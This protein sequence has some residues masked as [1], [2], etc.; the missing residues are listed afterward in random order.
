MVGRE[1]ELEQLRAAFDQVVADRSC[2][3]FTV[4][5]E[6]GVGKSRLV[7]EFHSGLKTTVAVGRCLP[8]GEGITYSPVVEVVKQL[9][10]RPTDGR[11][12]AAIGSLLGEAAEGSSAEEIAWAFRKTLE[13]A[14]AERP[15]VVVFDDIQWGEQTF[16]DLVEHVA[17]LSSGAP[18][19]LLCMARP[20]LIEHR[21][22]WPAALELQ[23]LPDEA[24]ER[25]IPAVIDGTLR[26]RIAKSAGGNPLFVEE[27]VVMAAEAEGEVRVPPS[28]R[29]L[30][31][32]RLER[33]D[34]DERR[35]LECASVEGEVFHR[36]AVQALA[37]SD[38]RVTGG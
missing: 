13:Q 26:E 6:A 9:S 29:A 10:V 5:G 27:L 12:A 32:A 35:V 30:L 2:R 24:V 19:L 7:R 1:R 31:A 21:P 4:V 8:Y 34:R 37:A 38:A 23:P 33:M 11:V 16:L 15:L 22:G 3:L 25:L 20:E 36:G 14:A 17:L 28:L 18:I